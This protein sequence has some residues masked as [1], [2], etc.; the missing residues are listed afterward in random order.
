MIICTFTTYHIH[1]QPII[2]DKGHIDF[3]T[4]SNDYIQ[5]S[6]DIYDESGKKIGTEEINT[7]E[8]IQASRPIDIK[9]T[10][11][12]KLVDD[13]ILIDEIAH[14]D[15][16]HNSTAKLITRDEIDHS[17]TSYATPKQETQIKQQST[18]DIID[19]VFSR[20][21]C[22]PKINID[23]DWDNIPVAQIDTLINYLDVPASDVADYIITKYINSDVLSEE[24]TRRLSQTQ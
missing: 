6:E 18:F 7:S 24:I 17:I 1:S 20:A 21:G 8:I 3:Q 5:A 22:Q 23:I 2:T 11:K 16:Q 12:N 4:F 15:E 9:H 19:K 10:Q 14:D 13:F